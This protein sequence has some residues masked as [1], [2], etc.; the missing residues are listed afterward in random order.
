MHATALT[1]SWGDITVALGPDQVV[2]SNAAFTIQFDR[3]ILP[4]DAARQSVCLQPGTD[5]ITKLEQ[6]TQG[7]RLEPRYDPVTRTVIYYPNGVLESAG[8][9]VYTLTVFSAANGGKGFRAFDGT[10]LVFDDPAKGLSVSFKVG[11]S[12]GQVP[13]PPPTDFPFCNRCRLGCETLEYVDAAKDNPGA[14][15]IL[16]QQCGGNCHK[17]DASVK[18]AA[19]PAMGLELDSLLAVRLTANDVVAHGTQLGG[20]AN[21][22]TV[23]PPHFGVAMA[24]IKPGDPGN[25]YV[26][27]K[28]LANPAVDQW[29]ESSTLAA[30]ETERLRRSLV[31]GMPMPAAPYPGLTH[32]EATIVSDWI[33]GGAGAKPC[34]VTP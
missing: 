2:Q 24:R 33:A 21:A 22:P 1:A 6:C 18:P 12:L 25:S 28:I 16:H 15:Q 5:Q 27:Y 3:Y 8:A 10:P 7:V 32:K 14:G 4:T 26:I 29:A 23:N 13:P 34:E 17:F 31:V 30:G 19:P 9:D 20:H 11:S